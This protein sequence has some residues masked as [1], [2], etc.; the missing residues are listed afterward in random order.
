MNAKR[1]SATRLAENPNPCWEVVGLQSPLL[2][3]H[4]APRWIA[5]QYANGV[6]CSL[7]GG[8]V[9]LYRMRSCV[10]GGGKHQRLRAGRRFPGLGKTP[11]GLNA[12][13]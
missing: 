6:A 2:T 8:M 11:E 5:V 1:V 10:C 4:K 3:I 12:G 9:R 13:R 7:V